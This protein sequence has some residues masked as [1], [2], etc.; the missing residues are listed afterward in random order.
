LDEIKAQQKQI[1]DERRRLR[2]AAIA[3]RERIY[4]S[5]D[6]LRNKLKV[7][8]SL[9]SLACLSSFPYVSVRRAS[10]STRLSLWT[11]ATR[12]SVSSRLLC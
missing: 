6:K 9:P 5:V 3:Q 2:D 1:A 12:P 7:G 11:M 4:S 8:G 10:G